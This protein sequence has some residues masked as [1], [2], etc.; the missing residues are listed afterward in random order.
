MLGHYYDDSS[1]FL[2]DV[3]FSLF[4]H[5]LQFILIVTLTTLLTYTRLA[6]ACCVVV[7]F[8]SC[9]S[10]IVCWNTVHTESGLEGV[11]CLWKSLLQEWTGSFSELERLRK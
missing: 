7:R 2:F 6:S 5:S 11:S 9:F 3:V 10:Q 4:C 1:V 8:S